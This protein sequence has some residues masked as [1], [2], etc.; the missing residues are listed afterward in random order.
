MPLAAR[1]DAK[2]RASS[3]PSGPAHCRDEWVK[4]WTAR[5]R[6]REPWE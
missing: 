2:A 3:S 4:G 6:R 5:L 1:A